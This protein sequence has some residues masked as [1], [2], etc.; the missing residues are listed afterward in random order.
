MNGAGWFEL[1]KMAIREDRRN[2]WIGRALLAQV[3][4]AARTLGV[5][6]LT[7][8]TNR[9]LANAIHRYESLGFRHLQSSRIEPSPYKRV[10]VY[11]EMLL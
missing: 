9:K 8:Q 1:A 2:Q 7:L 10:D 11:M 3:V 5:R 4:E 6:K